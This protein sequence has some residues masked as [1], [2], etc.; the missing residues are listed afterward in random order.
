MIPSIPK[1]GLYQPYPHSF[2]GLQAVVVKLAR[3]LPDF[4]FEPIIISPEP[5]Q[6]TERLRAENLPFMVSDPGDDWHVYGRGA[7]ALSYLTS[8]KRIFSLWRYWRK[9]SRDLRDR[10]IALLHCNDY[11]AVM[12]AAPAAHL[13]GIPVIWHMHGFVSSRL[14]NLLASAL[15]QWTVPVSK[16]M[17]DYLGSV[18]TL[19]GK[20]R[21][22]H[23]GLETDSADLVGTPRDSTTPLILAIGT[24][25][26]R[27]RYETLL[28]AFHEVL[29]YCHEAECWI[30]GGEFGDGSYARHLRAMAATLGLDGKLKFTGHSSAVHDYLRRSSLL[31]IP[32][33]IEAFGMV[34]IEAMQAGKPVVACR[35]GGLPD[36]IVHGKTGFLI[37]TDDHIGMASAIVKLLKNHSL[38][39]NMGMAGRSRV[40]EHFTVRKMTAS[41]ADFYTGLLRKA[42]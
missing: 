41:F 40:Q 35:T 3:A 4:G 1:I 29:T 2:G 10:S 12:L 34:A 39:K 17:L 14:A 22:I 15:V 23:N 9:L 32:S 24:L 7:N 16:G 31:V 6:F 42:A 19:F 21:V 26:P 13:A 28:R 37:D 38:A 5:G 25:H 18:R 11:R 8:P 20:C 36:I 33:R 27:K 30:V